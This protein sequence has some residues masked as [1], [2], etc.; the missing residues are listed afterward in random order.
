LLNRFSSIT[1]H[2]CSSGVN[3]FFELFIAACSTFFRARN[4]LLN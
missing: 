3:T 2:G 4:G 1:V